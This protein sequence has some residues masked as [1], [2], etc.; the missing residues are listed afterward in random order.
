MSAGDSDTLPV[1]GETVPL[2]VPSMGEI[3]Y[4]SS[5]KSKNSLLR[6]EP[7]LVVVDLP[8]KTWRKMILPP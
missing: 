6:A 3:L 2:I 7:G 5:V 4:P 1:V 8:R